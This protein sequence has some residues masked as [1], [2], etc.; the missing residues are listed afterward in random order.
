MTIKTITEEEI[1]SFLISTDLNEMSK[2]IF[3]VD[4]STLSKS[5][6]PHPAYK[7]FLVAKRNGGH[8]VISEPR[9][10]LKNYQLALLRYLYKEAGEFK[11][12]VHGFVPGR[13]IVS[14]ATA[15]CSQKTKHLLN[16]DIQNFFPSITFYR[17]RGLFMSRPF[18]FS[19]NVATVL[20][21]VCCYQGTLPQGAPTSPLIANL[22]CRNLDKELMALAQK[23]RANYTRYCDDITF[24]LSQKDSARLPK[25]ICT[26]DS[27]VVSLGEEL[28][29]HFSK[30]SFTI[31][32]LKTRVSSTRHRLEVT[33]LLIN[34]FPNVKRVFVDTIRGGLHAWEKYGYKNA[35]E[36]FQKKAY[37]R[38]TRSRKKP[39]L[40][41]Y[42]RGKI[43]FIK[44]VRGEDDFI[45]SKLAI[46]YNKLC[47]K[48]SEL[49]SSF[50]YKELSTS[51]LVKNMGGAYRAVFVVECTADDPTDGIIYSQGSAF[52]IE[53]IGLITCEHTLRV[54]ESYVEDMPGGSVEI[55]E[56]S[57][58]KRWKAKCSHRDKNR[59]LA[60]L[61]IVDPDPPEHLIF[62]ARE[63]AISIS[64]SCAIMGFPNYSSGR[65][66]ANYHTSSVLNYFPRTDLQRI[67]VKDTIRAGNSGGPLL[68]S[69][70]RIAGIV[71]QGATIH[72]GNNECL[73]ITE[74]TKWATSI[75]K[76]A[77]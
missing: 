43:L 59:D 73:C 41:N 68:D 77:E 31:N 72:E 18:R 29:H 3:G 23:H 33:G 26:Y 42:I 55:I 37:K 76:S 4:Y 70:Y 17:V 60:I 25:N 28:Q 58:L 36:H 24:S 15:H 49:D 44:M 22:I 56:A 40:A 1:K 7:T 27:G 11:R 50:A 39:S 67:E 64:E 34:K 2:E 63:T 14:N 74:I 62:A 8:R 30:N 57:T 61:E 75:K 19:Y 13:S 16:L 48:Q 66:T 53:N 38:A 20:A 45:Y 32:P 9:Q 47:R 12:C 52:F 10:T 51:S 21:Q 5:I 71:Q 54:D 65:K 35:N 6:Y 69:S 46:R